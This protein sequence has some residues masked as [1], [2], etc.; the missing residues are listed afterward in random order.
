MTSDKKNPLW[1][2]RFA[3][4]PA[5]AF[6]R[7]GHSLDA[8][9][10]LWRED[11][12]GSKA[13]ARMLGATGII[14]EEDAKTLVRGLDQVSGEIEEGNFEWS[15]AL[16]D[17]HMNIEARL[18]E[19]VGEVAGKLHTGRSRN[20]Q[21][22][23]DLRLWTRAAL[24]RC[25]AAVREVQKAFLHQAEQ[26]HDALMPGF[27]HLQIAQPVTYA[28][29]CLAYIEMLERD[30]LRLLSAREHLNESP[31]GA[32]ALGGTPHPIDREMTAKALG[33]ARPMA[34][35]LDAASARDFCL[36]AV[37]AATICGVTLSRYAEEVVTFSS[38]PFGYWKCSESFSTGSSIMPQKRN[39][40][41]A[42]LIRAKVGRLAGA[43]TALTLQTKGLALAYAKDMQETKPVTMDALETL[44][45]T[46][47][48][49]AGMVREMTI[50]RDRMA[51][52]A[53]AGYATATD[54]ADSL[55]KD[56]M[57]FR[58]AHEVVGRLVALCEEKGCT[59]SE[60]PLDEARKI[61]PLLT[62]ERLAALTPE[63]SVRGKKSAGGP[64]FTR[65]AASR[66][67]RVL[68]S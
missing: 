19:I 37:S 61:S 32:A 47:V 68:G 13:H 12:E 43:F 27:T 18:R 2:G 11:I 41:A 24:D 65:E 40:D 14:T 28:H 35:S 25:A 29:H 66:W 58:E 60:A 49:T 34:N 36:E 52:D 9:L 38:A 51:E 30:R 59:L 53:G 7:F 31:L 42:E 67:S 16:E 20:D 56:G 10:K 62:E 22:A 57:P 23:T 8:D 50:N 64:A 63:A 26:G 45:A 15:V 54:L 4:G 1:G 55:A 44:E 33:F 46:L 3:A 6:Q 39:P 17:V 5:E 48:I 21:V